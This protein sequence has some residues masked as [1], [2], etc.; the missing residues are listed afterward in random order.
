MSRSGYSEECQGGEF[1]LWRGA[2][3]AA[4]YGKRGQAFL[5]EML[6][7]LDAMPEKALVA[8]ILVAR[9]GCC[10]MGA[11]AARR[12]LDT[13]AVDQYDRNGVAELFGIAP[14]LAAEIAYVNDEGGPYYREEL[15]AERY[16][17]VRQWVVDSLCALEPKP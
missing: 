11:V 17:R 13:S 7:A 2:V 3:T 12:G 10:A 14:A 15:P 9:E 1:N 4:L 5:R 8:S 16:R 6:D